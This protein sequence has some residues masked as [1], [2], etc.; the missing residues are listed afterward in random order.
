MATR[1]SL[2]MLRLVQGAAPIVII[3]CGI[4]TASHL[5]GLALLGILLACVFLSLPEWLMQRFNLGKNAAIGLTV[6]SLGTLSL[7]TVFYLYERI[8]HLSDKLPAYHDHFMVLYEK[9]LVLLNAHGINLVSHSSTKLSSSDR[10]PELSRVVLPE[11]GRVLSDGLLISVLGLIFLI[12]MVESPEARR[13]PLSERLHSH[14]DDVRRYIA[15]SA[16]TGA[17]TA[18]ANLVLLLVLGVDFPAVWCVLYFFP[19]LH[20]QPGFHNLNTVSCLSWKWRKRSSVK[21]TERTHEETTEALHAGRESRHS[22]EAFGGRS[23]DLGSV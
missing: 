4:S 9:V 10:F 20:P 13:G 2:P 7:V 14:S 18:L 5:I 6:A 11:A 23:A 19:T 3:M 8:S 21:I 1:L 22:E 17:I 15:I 16:K 12:V